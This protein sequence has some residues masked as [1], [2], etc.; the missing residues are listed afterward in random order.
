VPPAPRGSKLGFVN[1]S[2]D[3]GGSHPTGDHR[4]QRLH[5]LRQP[6]SAIL[7]AASALRLDHGLEPSTRERL[8]TIVI[9]NAERLSEM[10]DAPSEPD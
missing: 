4:A 1:I 7:A 9:D 6:L 2:E 10:L 5:D 8:I 3:G